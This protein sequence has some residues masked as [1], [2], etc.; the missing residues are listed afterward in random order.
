MRFA[1]Q[2]AD[3]MQPIFKTGRDMCRG[4]KTILPPNAGSQVERKDGAQGGVALSPSAVKAVVLGMATALSRPSR[5]GSML[6]PVSLIR[7]V[8]R[9]CLFWISRHVC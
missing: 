3:F 7:V 4:R 6:W 9:V 8:Q 5:S 2:H 1:L